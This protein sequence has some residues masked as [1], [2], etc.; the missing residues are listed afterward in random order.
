MSL[1]F[2]AKSYDCEY[3]DVG[4]EDGQVVATFV[5][6]FPAADQITAEEAT[7]IVN[8]PLFFDLLRMAYEK[9]QVGTPLFDAFDRMRRKGGSVVVKF[10]QSEIEVAA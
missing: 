7:A 8:T 1:N 3:L 4:A 9:A 10:Q 6:N 2:I 5:G